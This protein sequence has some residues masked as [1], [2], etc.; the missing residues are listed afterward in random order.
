M[1]E[2]ENLGYTMLHRAVHI[3]TLL[4]LIGEGGPKIDPTSLSTDM[5]ISMRRTAWGLYQLDT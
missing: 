3:G 1:A 2:D 5:L 4:G